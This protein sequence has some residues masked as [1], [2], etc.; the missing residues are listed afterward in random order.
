MQEIEFELSDLIGEQRD[1]AEVIGLKSYIELVKIYG[2]TT[3]YIAKY[4]KIKNMNRDRKIIQ[5]F[6]GYNYK[7][8]AIKY[9]LSDRAVREIISN[10]RNIQ[11]KS[12]LEF[13]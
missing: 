10:E 1:L 8:L 4:D 9:N 5:E 6:N 13:E 12:Q 11:N 2:G 7:Y 3:I